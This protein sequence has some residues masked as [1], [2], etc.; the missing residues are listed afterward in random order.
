MIISAVYIDTSCDP[1]HCSMQFLRKYDWTM[2]HSSV[3][4]WPYYKKNATLDSNQRT[5]SPATFLHVQ[6]HCSACYIYFSKWKKTSLLIC[7]C[8]SHALLLHA[9]PV[10]K[11]SRTNHFDA[12]TII[13]YRDTMQY[14]DLP[15]RFCL[16]GRTV[17]NLLFSP[18]LSRLFTMAIAV[19][20]PEGR[21]RTKMAA[22]RT[23]TML[24]M[25]VRIAL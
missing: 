9:A 13:L 8:S 25:A 15:V 21:R 6:L 12:R 2:P 4:Y 18:N 17:S 14:V 19:T 20:L 7:Y 10:Y 16:A 24:T 22:Y 1:R 3:H 23:T 11:L 5:V